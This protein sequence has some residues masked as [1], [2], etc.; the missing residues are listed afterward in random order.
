MKVPFGISSKTLRKKL[1]LISTL[2]LVSVIAYSSQTDMHSTLSST[3]LALRNSAIVGAA[4][5]NQALSVYIW[6][7][8]Q[9]NAA[10][11]KLVNDIYTQ[12]SPNFHKFLTPD[13]FRQQ[14]A[15]TN[16]AVNSVKQYFTNNGMQIGYIPPSNAFVEVKGTVAQF[17]QVFNVNINNYQYKGRV[18]YSNDRDV[19]LDASLVNVTQAITGLNSFQV[20]HH[21][22]VKRSAVANSAVGSGVTIPVLMQKAYGMDKLY[23]KGLDGSGQTIAIV[24]AYDDTSVENDLNYSSQHFGLPACTSASGCF[25]KLNEYGQAAPLPAVSPANDDWSPEVSIDTQSAHSM[26][27]GAK[28]ILL[29]ANSPNNNDLYAAIETV[30]NNNLANVISNSWSGQEEPND[31]STLLFMQAAAQG[32][33]V[34][35]ST[36]D[37]ADN[38]GTGTANQQVKP[39]INYPGSSPYAT[40]VGGTYLALNPNGS[41]RMETGW[42]W[43]WQDSGST[44]GLSSY[45]TAPIWQQQ[46][47]SNANAGGYGVVGTRRAQ[48]DISLLGD[49][50]SGFPIY[51]SSP[52]DPNSGLVNGWG[53]YGGTSLACPMYT[54]IIAVANQARASAGKTTVGLTTQYLYN[55]PMSVH[56]GQAPITNIVAPAATPFSVLT[57]NPSGW[58]DITGLGSVYAPLFVQYLLNN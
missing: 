41:Y 54:A 14:F 9:N 44:G 26:A 15:P 40:G 4:D 55:M 46:A 30:V 1:L 20:M 34:N 12:G 21:N 51:D 18:S 6:L 52:S 32:I 35:F 33:S 36:G 31:P 16:D 17:Q 48:P 39:T 22:Y 47:I 25:T 23:S 50:M 3:P 13:Q 38:M 28:I 10:L 29:E 43:S 56:Y 19:S 57:A 5:Q 2:S 24:D 58:N 7:K 45:Y 37:S 42:A 53:V 27:P 11:E 49:P 8:P